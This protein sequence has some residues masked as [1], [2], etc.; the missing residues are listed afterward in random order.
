MLIYIY[1]RLADVKRREAELDV[2]AEQ[3]GKIGSM[4]AEDQELVQHQRR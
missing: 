2:T 1:R 4:L 3:L